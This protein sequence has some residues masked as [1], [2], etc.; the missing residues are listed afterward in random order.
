M[1]RWVGPIPTPTAIT[2][3]EAHYILLANAPRVIHV[4]LHAVIAVGI[5]GHLAKLWKANES[6]YLF[7]GASLVLY[8][9]AVVLY[10]TSVIQGL[11]EMISHWLPGLR[12]VAAGDF[13]EMAKV[14]TLRVMAASHVILA[15]VLIGNWGFFFITNLGV[16]LLQGGQWY[17]EIAALREL[18]EI[19]ASEREREEAKK[20]E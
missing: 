20:S 19:E 4:V 18:K 17:A 3:S 9:I 5:F 2:A 11:F 10:G 15:V 6:N 1:I 13:R 16:L 12:S 14:D 8:M 7:D